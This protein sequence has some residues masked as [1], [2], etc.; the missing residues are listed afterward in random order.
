MVEETEKSNENSHAK[1]DVSDKVTISEEASNPKACAV[2]P[3]ISPSETEAEVPSSSIIFK[4]DQCCFT[5]NSDKGLKVHMRMKKH[6]I[7]QLDGHEEEV[8]SD[9]IYGVSVTHKISVNEKK[10]RDEM[11]NYLTHFELWDKLC[12]MGNFMVKEVELDIFSVEVNCLEKEYPEDFTGSQAAN[13]LTSLPWPPD[14]SVI[15]SQPP[16]YLTE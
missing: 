6:P 14:Y 2:K 8:K 12:L 15:S 13:F 7:P 5:S 9:T 11:K 16:S 1:N 4:C 10:T 3:T